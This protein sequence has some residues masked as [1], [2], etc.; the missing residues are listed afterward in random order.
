MRTIIDIPEAQRDALD[1]ILA[2]KPVE[3]PR[4][5]AVGCPIPTTPTAK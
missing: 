2:D 4:T 1:A 5:E 3:Q